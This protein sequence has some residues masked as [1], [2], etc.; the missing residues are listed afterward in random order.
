MD[1]YDKILLFLL[2]FVFLVIVIIL[3]D[4][5][6]VQAQSNEIR[7]EFVFPFSPDLVIGS[8]VDSQGAFHR[9]YPTRE[10]DVWIYTL[11]GLV[12]PFN[13][14]VNAWFSNTQYS[15]GILTANGS[16]RYENGQLIPLPSS[17]TPADLTG[18]YQRLD[19]LNTSLYEVSYISTQQYITTVT[20]MGLLVVA[21][22]IYLTERFLRM[23]WYHLVQVWL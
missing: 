23:I 17:S 16:F 14:G 8:V 15:T 13:F 11:S 2:A 1:K 21:L 9:I 22:T 19:N 6:I 7:M 4:S 10:G 3:I 5:K 12:A 20:I 18:I